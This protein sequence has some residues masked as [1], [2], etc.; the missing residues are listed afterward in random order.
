[1]D[2]GILEQDFPKIG[3]FDDVNDCNIEETLERSVTAELASAELNLEIENRRCKCPD[4]PMKSLYCGKAH[5][6]NFTYFVLVDRYSNWP[7]VCQTSGG[8][9]EDLILFLRKH[10]KN[11]GVPEVIT[12]DG[13]PEFV[14]Y[15][16]LSFLKR[17]GVK[18]R[19][20][21][22]CYPRVFTRA[23][24]GIESIKRLLRNN[25]ATSGSLDCD[26][27][28]RAILRYRNTPCRDIG[29]S[30]SNILFGRNLKEQ[31]SATT[32]ILKETGGNGWNAYRRSTRLV[33]E[34]K[35]ANGGD[36][37]KG[38]DKQRKDGQKGGDRP[39]TKLN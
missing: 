14:T 15:E 29:V 33:E 11:F 26:G 38:G 21:S 4:Y 32:D 12:S 19:L 10:F 13:S 34:H 1:M 22:A 31:L 28:S 17:W 37:R 36:K 6:G 9:A 35:K 20:S 39:R 8:G 23:E 3:R 5:I 25:T 2:L 27:F 30:P 24:F 18:Q 16:V 7:S